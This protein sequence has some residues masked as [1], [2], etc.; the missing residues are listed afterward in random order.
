MN[1][2]IV[3]LSF[4]TIYVMYIRGH[5]KELI[6][7]GFKGTDKSKWFS[8]G[9]VYGLV[10]VFFIVFIEMVLRARRLEIDRK[11]VV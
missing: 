9:F 3:L 10:I 5:E 4:L 2:L 8:T 6:F 1:R 11:S 7:F